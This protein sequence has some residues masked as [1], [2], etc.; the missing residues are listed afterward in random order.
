M[1]SEGGAARGRGGRGRGGVEHETSAGG[2]VIRG[3]RGRERVVAIV[4][5]RRAPDGSHVLGLPKGHIDPGESELAAAVREVREETGVV[6]EPV[7]DLGEVRYWYRRGGRRIS[8]SVAF[9][10]LRYVSG[11][12]SEHD[13]EVLEARWVDLRSALGELTYEGEREM[14]ARAIT[15]LEAQDR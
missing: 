1:S 11:D 5:V 6:A 9:F 3:E 15:L 14:I 7:C 12:T 10:L 13:E 2:V 4:P 8:K